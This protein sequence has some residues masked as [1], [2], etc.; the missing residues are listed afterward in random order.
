MQHYQELIFF[1]PATPASLYKKALNRFYIKQIWCFFIIF[2][3]SLTVILTVI[4]KNVFLNSSEKLFFMIVF[5]QK[6]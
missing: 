4:L 2:I 3:R 5:E 1:R 6:L